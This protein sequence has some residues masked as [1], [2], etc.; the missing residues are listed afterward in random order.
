[1]AVGREQGVLE[2]RWG[3]KEGA[4]VPMGGQE[5]NCATLCQSRVSWVARSVLA[6]DFSSGHD[7]VVH[8]FKPH[9]GLLTDSVES[10]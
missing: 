8:E 9:S 1:M 4:V 10:D 3:S 5:V 7:L 2:A 6:S